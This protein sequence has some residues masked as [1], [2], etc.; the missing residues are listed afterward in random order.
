MKVTST[1]DMAFRR[2]AIHGDWCLSEV[3]GRLMVVC[4]CGAQLYEQAT[5]PRNALERRQA[6]I[7]LDRL[8]V[9]ARYGFRLAPGEQ[10]LVEGVS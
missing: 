4:E 5:A 1:D 10:P 3:H 8:T 2:H 7:A 6:A 9:Q